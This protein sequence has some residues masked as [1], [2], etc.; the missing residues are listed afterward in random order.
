MLELLEKTKPINGIYVCCCPNRPLETSWGDATHANTM[1]WTYEY[2]TVLNKM[3]CE[4]NLLGYFSSLG[5]V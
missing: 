4:A 2:C 3:L 1:G 5:C